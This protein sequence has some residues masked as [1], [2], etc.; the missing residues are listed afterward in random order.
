MASTYVEL[1][2]IVVCKLYDRLMM[3]CDSL[4]PKDAHKF[5]NDFGENTEKE[6]FHEKELAKSKG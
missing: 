1:K 2:K 3:L 4:K 6:T 5:M